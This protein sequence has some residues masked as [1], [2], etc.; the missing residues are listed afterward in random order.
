VCLRWNWIL[1]VNC[2]ST[3]WFCCCNSVYGPWVWGN[4]PQKAHLSTNDALKTIKIFCYISF[5]YDWQSSLLFATLRLALNLSAAKEKTPNL[6]FLVF[7]LSLLWKSDFVVTLYGQ[8]HFEAL[9][10]NLISSI[11]LFHSSSIII[12]IVVFF[13]TLHI[14]HMCV[15]LSFYRSIMNVNQI[16]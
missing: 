7:H 15:F 4:I 1:F 12:I 3:S 11:R 8:K 10:G 14:W 9:P 5:T 2:K 16:S 6:Q 13:F